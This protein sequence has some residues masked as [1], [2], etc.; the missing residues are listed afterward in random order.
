[1]HLIQDKHPIRSFEGNSHIN[2]IILH[3]EK[4]EIYL[5][6][7]LNPCWNSSMILRKVLPV[8][9]ELQYSNGREG[10]IIGMRRR[11]SGYLNGIDRSCSITGIGQSQCKNVSKKIL[12][13]T[14]KLALACLWQTYAAR[15]AKWIP[16][17]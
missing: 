14:F 11:E 2:G 17:K 5:G 7:L 3:M 6:D 13:R 15:S 16:P 4:I 8:I 12:V 1:M 9:L 10:I